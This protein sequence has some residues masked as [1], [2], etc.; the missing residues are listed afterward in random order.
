[1]DPD[2]GILFAC[3]SNERCSQPGHTCG[4]DGLCRPDS[5]RGDDAPVEFGHVKPPVISSS[6]AGSG[7][8]SNQKATSSS[9][10]RRT[11]HDCA[12]RCAK[13]Q[14]ECTAQCESRAQCRQHC[15][16]A[17][18]ICYARCQ[19]VNDTRAMARQRRDDKHCM[20][21]G[22]TMR[23]CSAAEDKELRAAMVQASKMFCRDRSGEPVLCPGQVEQLKKAGR[24]ICEGPG[25]E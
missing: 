13:R 19:R 2:E 8:S 10:E 24:F 22:G 20:S 12:Q 7:G 23:R 11:D 6:A 21:G 15:G 9:R 16:R 4:L 18:D 3:D 14:A 5:K 17:S 25:R 1:M